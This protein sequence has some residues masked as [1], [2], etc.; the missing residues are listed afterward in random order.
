MTRWMFEPGHTAAEFRGRHMMVTWVRGSFKDIHGWLELDWEHCL[1]ATFGG[2]IDAT[3]LWS[4]EPMRDEHLRSPDF[5]DVQNHP[6]I[7]FEGRFISRTGATHFKGEADVTIRGNTRTVPLDIAYLGEWQTPFW[8][9]D[10]N[11]GEL[12]RIGFEARTRVDRTDFGVSWQDQ[13]A[14]GGVVASTEI[15]LTLDVE[16]IHE[17][18]LHETGAIRYYEPE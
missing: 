13:I 11:R 9:G 12:R 6:K 14:G 18:D 1:D 7:T 8:D 4:G 3:K 10:V 5:F 2:E 17:G 15:D 16:A